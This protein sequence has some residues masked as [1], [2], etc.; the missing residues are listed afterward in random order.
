MVHHDA[1]KSYDDQEEIKARQDKT[2]EVGLD[3]S[4]NVPFEVS[5]LFLHH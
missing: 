2:K 3:C 4:C 1:E 5:L